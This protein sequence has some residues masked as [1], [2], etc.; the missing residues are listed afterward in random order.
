VSCWQELSDQY[1][2]SLVR[3]LQKAFRSTTIPSE[4]LQA[5]LN[6][7]EFMEHDVEALPISLSILAEL[8]QKGHAYAKALHYR[9]LEFQTN[10]AGCFESL[11]NINKKLD[12][13]DAASGLLKVVE[14]IQKKFP[15]LKDVYAVQES[16]LAKL[17]HWD[18]ALVKYDAK[19]ALNP[20]D[21]TLLAGKLKCLDALGRWEEAVHLCEENLD[22]MRIESEGSGGGGG[23]GSS[24]V[25]G[26][27]GGQSHNGLGHYNSFGSSSGGA[28]G[29]GNALQQAAAAAASNTSGG[30]GTLSGV[31]AGTSGALSGANS[32][33]ARALTKAA[34]IGARAAW[35][36]NQWDRMD[37]FL[38]QLPGNQSASLLFCLLLRFLFS[39]FSVAA[40]AFFS[41][42][43]QLMLRFHCYVLR[44]L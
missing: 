19:L 34:V 16:W 32:V 41:W 37:L 33:G 12:Q 38:S 14:Q 3:S 28:G 9:E 30:A 2:E 21:G 1:Q 4:I 40:V 42:L 43:F 29:G 8:A 15:T 18:A 26:G 10:P 25:I 13:Y 5:L 24:S 11:I 22:M 31:S 17:G 6:L 39:F 7:A 23:G 20:R 44:L 35:S 36:L 27:G